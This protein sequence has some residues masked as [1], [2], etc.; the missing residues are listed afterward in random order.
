MNTGAPSRSAAIAEP[1]AAMNLSSSARSSA[2][3]QRQSEKRVV[4]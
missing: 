2:D 3:T 1:C 4:S